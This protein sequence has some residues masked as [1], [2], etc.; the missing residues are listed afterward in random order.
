V[1]Y[2][3]YHNKSGNQSMSGHISILLAIENPQFRTPTETMCYHGE[4][5]TSQ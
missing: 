5:M 4:N 1:L 2:G 3:G